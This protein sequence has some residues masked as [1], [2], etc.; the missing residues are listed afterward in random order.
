MVCRALKSKNNRSHAF[1]DKHPEVMTYEYWN[2][3]V[4][5]GY[6]L[7]FAIRFS[8]VCETLSWR[9]QS[10]EFFMLGPIFLHG[11]CPVNIQ[12]EFTGHRNLFADHEVEI[13]QRWITGRDSKKHLGQC[14]QQPRLEN[15][16]GLCS[17][18]NQKS[19]KVIRGRKLW[20]RTQAGCLRV[21]RD[22]N[23][24]MPF[25][26]SL[27]EISQGQGSSE[28]AHTSGFARQYTDDN[29]HNGRENSRC[30]HPGRAMLGATGDLYHGSGVSGLCPALFHSHYTGIFCN[31]GEKESRFQAII[32]TTDKKG[33]RDK[34]RPNWDANKLLFKKTLSGKD[35]AYRLCRPGDSQTI[36]ISDQQYETVG[37]SY[38]R[39][40]QIALAGG[41]F[42]Q[43]DKA[44]FTDQSFLWDD[45]ERC[46]DANL[47]RNLNLCADRHYSEGTQFKAVTLHNSTDFKRGSFR[48]NAHFT[49][50]CG[51]SLC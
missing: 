5:S 51:E 20:R 43:M 1:R 44:A 18:I 9:L 21:R 14:Q 41:T 3:F 30:K 35:S 8:S 23:R 24:F 10:K 39:S 16:R 46:K 45:R 47:D 29:Y 31:Q 17:D 25:S 40:L 4:L 13:A 50:V 15:L 22:N 49:G 11:L 26:I 7:H 34:I 36:D 6:G 28:V 19:E 48:E 12:G 38:R 33:G 37:K 42:L 32:F 2:D 27:G